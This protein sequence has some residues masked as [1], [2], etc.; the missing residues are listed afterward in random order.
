VT[1]HGTPII[2]F[3]ILNDVYLL[4][5][6]KGRVSNNIERPEN[7]EIKSVRKGFRATMWYAVAFPCVLL[8]SFLVISFCAEQTQKMEQDRDG[9]VEMDI[10]NFDECAAMMQYYTSTGELTKDH[11][12]YQIT[13]RYLSQASPFSRNK[14]WREDVDN[15]AVVKSFCQTM[16]NSFGS[17]A[18][19]LL[20]GGAG[21]GGEPSLEHSKAALHFN[22]ANTGAFHPRSVRR[23]NPAM[24][25]D[26][27]VQM[28][29]VLNFASMVLEHSPESCFSPLLEKVVMVVSLQRDGMAIKRGLQTCYATMTN[30]GIAG[31]N[32][33][34]EEANVHKD[35][36]DTEVSGA[37]T[38]SLAQRG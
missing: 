30:C 23:S 19:M 7:R 22:T 37:L 12:F 2:K 17:G 5:D 24:Y 33:H 9:Y 10:T 29:D 13:H 18:V 11:L 1:L 21:D 28:E 16:Q 27:G 38:R 31:R 20:H 8:L 32:M 34:F 26:E 4:T 25:P 35:F 3:F 36:S 15:H 14:Q 6:R